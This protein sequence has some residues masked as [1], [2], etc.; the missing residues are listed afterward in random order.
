MASRHLGGCEPEERY[1]RQG[2]L[3]RVLGFGSYETAW[4]WLQKIRRC[5]VR[6]QREP[7]QG[8]LQVDE[9]F[10]GGKAESSTRGRSTEHKSLIMVATEAENGRV[11]LEHAPRGTAE[12]AASFIKRNIGDQ[13]VLHTDGCGIYNPESLG[14]RRHKARIQ[15]P[16]EGEKRSK[17]DVV[18]KCHW[19]MANLKRWWLGTHH[20]AISKKH[21]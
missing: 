4:T 15:T 11:R 5:L 21:L 16:K 9:G 18:Q 20:G 6:D 14:D 12:H 1:Q 10:L 13:A 8:L 7:L 19:T 2:S 3:Q 17:K